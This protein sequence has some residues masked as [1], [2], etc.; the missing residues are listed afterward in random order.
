MK[1]DRTKNYQIY[2]NYFHPSRSKLFSRKKTFFVAE[3]T[4]F[5]NLRTQLG[6]TYDSCS[7]WVLI[8]GSISGHVWYG[9]HWNLSN[10]PYRERDVTTLPS[11]PNFSQLF[12]GVAIQQQLLFVL[13]PAAACVGATKQRTTFLLPSNLFA[14]PLAP[15]RKQIGRQAEGEDRKKP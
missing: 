11:I 9:S 7:L 3:K 1:I 10:L 5:Q 14:A 4:F 15:G 6:A 2:T 12:L 8:R 13:Y